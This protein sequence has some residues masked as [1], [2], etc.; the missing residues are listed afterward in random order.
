MVCQ[1]EC[2]HRANFG[3]AL[4]L[5]MVTARIIDAV[6]TN[7]A[8]EKRAIRGILRFKLMLTVHSKGSGIESRYRSVMMLSIT[9]TRTYTGEFVGWQ[10]SVRIRLHLRFFAC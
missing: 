4:T 7:A 1:K 6:M 2:T 10:N 8:P 3:T 9:T 5:I